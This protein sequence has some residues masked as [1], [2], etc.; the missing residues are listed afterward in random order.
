M[1]FI[2]C[3]GVSSSCS[4][5]RQLL[6]TQ[7]KAFLMESND[8]RQASC[9]HD[10]PQTALQVCH[11]DLLGQKYK[12]LSPLNIACLCTL[13]QGVIAVHFP[14]LLSGTVDGW[15][16]C[17]CASRTGPCWQQDLCHDVV[18]NNFHSQLLVGLVAFRETRNASV[19]SIQTPLLGHYPSMHLWLTSCNSFEVQ[20]GETA[21][22]SRTKPKFNIAR[23]LI[24]SSSS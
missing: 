16:C 3:P 9:R 7:G 17:C 4:S 21:H 10:P 19:T 1:D 13:C 6:E 11:T 5:P 20:G 23:N 24:L 18:V 15:S 14:A 8:G 2:A 12:R 22:S